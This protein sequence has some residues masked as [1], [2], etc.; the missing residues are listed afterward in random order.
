LKDTSHLTLLEH[1][2]YTRLMDVY[3]VRESSLPQDQ[4]SRLIGARTAEELAALEC[5][6]SEFF[7]LNSGSWVQHRCEREIEAYS[8]KSIKAK[9]S[10][11]ARWENKN[12]NTEGNA[13]AMRTHTEGNAPINQY[14]LTNNQKKTRNTAT[15]VATPD[16][17]CESVW[18]DFCQQRKSKG[19]KLTQTAVDGIQREADRAG[20]N[21]EDALREIC[22]RGWTGFKADW[23]QTTNRRTDKR[24]I[25]AAFT[26][27]NTIDVGGLHVAAIKGH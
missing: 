24:A 3:Y 6:L 20:W 10:A 2:I 12:E 17:V 13:N 21:L 1:G 9:R 18:A 19:A 27:S 7:E 5:V 22:S 26:G 23:V 16:G 11:S 25:V 14:P 8:D 4:I 15:A